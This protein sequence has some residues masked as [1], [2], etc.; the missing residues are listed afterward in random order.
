MAK[1]KTWIVT[2]DGSRPIRTV[3]RELEAAGLGSPKV[4]A[5]VGSITGTASAR[6]VAALRKVGGVA[7][8]SPDFGIQLGPGDSDQT[9]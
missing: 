5:A 9:W 7:D 2:T 6:V 8:V 1:I 4:L 3:A